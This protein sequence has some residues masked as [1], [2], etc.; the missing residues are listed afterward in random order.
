MALPP[1]QTGGAPLEA[2]RDRASSFARAGRSENTTRAYESDLRLFGGWCGERGLPHLPTSAETISL[3]LSDMADLVMPAT[4]ERRIATIS[5]A[6]KTAGYDSPTEHSVVKAVLRGIRRQ[7]G[8]AQHRTRA[9]LTEDLRRLLKQIDDSKLIGVRDRALLLVGFAGGLR[10]SELVGLD[11]ENVGRF[12]PDGVVLTIR[13]SKT[14]QSAQGQE[15]SLVFGRDPVTCPIRALRAWLE[16]SDIVDGPVFRGM[17]RHGN[18]R[19]TRL[20]E[21]IVAKVVKQYAAR[22]GL[23]PTEFSGHSLRSGF[24][25]SAARGGASEAGIMR[26]TRHRSATMARRYIRN[27]TRWHDHAGRK[28]DL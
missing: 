27:G 22:A 1:P 25:T 28:L 12:E 20:T 26:Q 23:D 24:A 19:D 6:H 10:R 21:R 18:V 5:T 11:A 15:V 3:Y 9:L 8:A 13:K 14:D 7:K 17:D 2:L 4:L 16:A